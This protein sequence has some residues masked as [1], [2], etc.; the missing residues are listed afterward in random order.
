MYFPVI[1]TNTKNV[2][3]WTKYTEEGHVEKNVDLHREFWKPLSEWD[4][5]QV[6]SLF[7]DQI[8]IEVVQEEEDLEEEDLEEDDQE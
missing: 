5:A 6:E 1:D 7:G 8:I 4:D 2:W 3:A